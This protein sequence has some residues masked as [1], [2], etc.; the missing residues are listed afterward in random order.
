MLAWSYLES[1]GECWLQG[2]MG[3]LS[4]VCDCTLSQPELQ[5]G[6]GDTLEWAPQ[7]NVERLC[8]QKAEVLIGKLELFLLEMEKTQCDWVEQKIMGKFLF[9]EAGIR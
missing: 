1:Q 5:N 7:R 9:L 3:A 2:G 4:L 6:A 8:A